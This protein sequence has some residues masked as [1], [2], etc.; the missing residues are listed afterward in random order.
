MAVPL[1]ID[2]DLG[3]DDAVAVALALASDA[4]DVR[5]IV[6]VGGNVAV[7]QVQTNV[8]RLLTALAPPR[9]PVVGRGL[10]PAPTGA[11]DR[12]ALFGSDGLGECEWPAG[13]SVASRDFRD[14]YQACIE[15]GGGELTILATGPL[16]NLAAMAAESPE[17]MHRVKRI[18]FSGGAVW[19]PGNVR[20]LAEF[21][22]YRDPSAA[23]KVLSSGLP[24]TVAPLDV[25]Y[26]VCLD[27]SHV[28]HLA[29][30]GYRTG[31]VL[32]RILHH[33]VD[34]DADPGVGKAHVQDAI[35]AGAILWP[36]L[37]LKTRMR[38]EV[39][40]A[41]PEAG[42]CRPQLGGDSAQ[43]VDL[44]TAVNAV[45]LLE[46]LLESLCHEAFVV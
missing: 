20:G 42:K 14:V 23:A 1:L 31:Q 11:F 29:A 21:N 28:A 33:A 25:A 6:G 24:I 13:D 40:T 32:A 19:A 37:F 3:I 16:T 45:D 26:L 9:A 46:N 10:D 7:D 38:L 2:T 4:L 8:S 41:G 43:R 35:A 30:S 44:L 39:V 36:D 27:E 5:G 12:R 18:Y 34:G 17:L 22:L 15:E